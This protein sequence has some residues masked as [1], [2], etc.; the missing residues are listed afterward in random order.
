ME[1]NTMP[2]PAHLRRP[3]LKDIASGVFMFLASRASVMGMFPFGTAFFAAGVDKGVAYAGIAV[4][5]GGLV[6]AGAGL[7]VVKYLIADL[8]YWIYI[9]TRRG[10]S[11]IIESAVCGFSV[12]VGGAAMFAY[13]YIGMY[14]VMLLFIESIV[15]AVVYIVFVNTK[16]FLENRRSRSYVSQEEMVSIAVCAGIFITG[17]SDIN[18]PYGISLSA[19]AAMYVSM[20][21]ALCTNLAASGSG[22]LCIGFMSAMSSPLSALT[23]GAYGLGALFGNFLKNYGKVGAAVGFVGGVAA[24]SICMQGGAEQLSAADAAIAALLFVLTPK[25]IHKYINIFFSKSLR[26]EAVSADVRVKEYLSGKTERIAEAYKS[27]N[28]CFKAESDKRINLYRTEVGGLFDEMSHRVCAGCSMAVKCW[29]NDFTKTYKNV[30]TLL[31]TIETEG[32]LTV[33]SVPKSFSDKCIRR[34]VFVS[35]LN[36]VY[37]MYK[38]R[39]IRAGEA[40]YERDIIARQYEETARIFENLSNDVLEGFSFREDLEEDVVNAL[41]RLGISAYEVS[42]VENIVGRIEVY[43]GLGLGA[44]VKK[45]EEVLCEVFSVPM[46]RDKE[47]SGALMKFVSKPRYGA[48]VSLRQIKSDEAEISGD[49]VA[50]FTTENY[51]KYVIIA[52][53]MGSGKKAMQESRTTLR[54]LREFIMAGFEAETAIEMINSSLCLKMDS[55]MFST[56]DLLCIDLIYG[57]AEFYKIGAA[58]S[59]INRS[60]SIETVFSASV[61]AG[62]V[63]DIKPQG[64]LKRVYGGDMIVMMSDGVLE[65]ED[66][67]VRTEW[68]KQTLRTNPSDAEET[69]QGIME[70][71]TEKSHG[72]ISDDMTVAVVKITEN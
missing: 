22:A 29:N 7:S 20:C 41:D 72:I 13:D 36:H 46:G 68:I 55:E 66:G 47:Y 70:T 51:K 57:T 61:P 64:Q 33:S 5:C 63:A 21:M 4:M 71:V 58:E 42:V 16:I 34:D 56:I 35:E 43:L 27:L 3:A 24:V 8:L 67:T 15:S 25:K 9:K 30:M 37:E 26:M 14:D 48:D 2:S 52:D 45:A 11:R 54:L 65:A 10:E 69:A 28:K 19:I 18:L 49:S 17:L 59:L 60:G 6:S 40:V 38:K 44:D 23:G 50:S 32:V 31:E 62:M 53:G 12:L 1:I 39:L